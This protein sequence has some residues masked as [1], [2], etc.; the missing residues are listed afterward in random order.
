MRSERWFWLVGIL[1]GGTGLFGGV[2]L[3][4][5]DAWM[6]NMI[7]QRYRSQSFAAGLAVIMLFILGYSIR[8]LI[9]SFKEPKY[10]DRPY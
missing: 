8:N 2:W 10:P 6:Q 9:R 7:G 1:I 4:L 5:N 3:F